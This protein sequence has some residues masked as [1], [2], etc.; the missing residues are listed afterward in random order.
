MDPQP[1]G[2]EVKKISNS[3]AKN[4]ACPLCGSADARGMPSPVEFKRY[5][6][7]RCAACMHE[8]TEGHRGYK[9]ARRDAKG[10]K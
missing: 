4:V 6:S 7:F 5:R 2:G 8:W 9:Y 3:R 10:K 1:E